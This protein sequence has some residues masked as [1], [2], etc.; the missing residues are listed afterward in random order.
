MIQ[1][2]YLKS[3][4]PN[5]AHQ[6]F[7]SRPIEKMST[8]EIQIEEFVRQFARQFNVEWAI[9]KQWSDDYWGFVKPITVPASDISIPVA[10]SPNSR[11]RTGEQTSDESNQTKSRKKLE[12]TCV[13]VT[14]KDTK[15]KKKGELCA[16]K[17]AEQFCYQHKDS[18]QAK[19]LKPSVPSDE[20]APS[21]EKPAETSVPLTTHS[22]INHCHPKLQKRNP[23]KCDVTES[24]IHEQVN[25]IKFEK[26]KYNQYEHIATNLVMDK[27]TMTI[28]GKQVYDANGTISSLSLADV[29]LCNHLKLSYQNNKL[30]VTDIVVERELPMDDI[31]DEVEEDD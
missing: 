26:N 24:F 8:S 13:Y 12:N 23:F 3:Y 18:P 16:A 2:D 31:E 27:D 28:I 21:I 19:A 17:C 11:K 20:A 5:I 6:L 22:L 15:Y 29:E 10:S 25:K 4:V 14:P 9:A 7:Y 30:F 1:N